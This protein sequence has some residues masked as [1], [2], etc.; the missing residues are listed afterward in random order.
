[1][2]DSSFTV[3]DLAQEIRRVDGNHSLGAGALAEML[4][5]F[6]VK[7]IQAERERCAAIPMQFAIPGHAVA[8]P[9][10]MDAMAK[11]ILAA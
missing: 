8:G 1:M 2:I 6:F 10:R 11:A 4:M 5:P 3:D 7:A 9:A